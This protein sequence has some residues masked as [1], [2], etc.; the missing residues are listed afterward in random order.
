MLRRNSTFLLLALLLLVLHP[1][2]SDAQCSASVDLNTW[3]QQGPP[4]AGNWIVNPPGTQ[5]VQTINGSPS[6]FVSPQSF[7]N[8]RMTGSFSTPGPDDDFMGFVFGYQGA[9]GGAGPIYNMKTFL[10][11]WNQVPHGCSNPGRYLV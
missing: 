11:D 2:Q 7:I 10:F 1:L 3:S 9:I 6:F 8:V 4:T 5:V